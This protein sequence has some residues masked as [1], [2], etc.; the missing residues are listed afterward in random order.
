MD[1]HRDFTGLNKRQANTQ[2]PFGASRRWRSASD[3][4]IASGVAQADRRTFTEQGSRTRSHHE[5]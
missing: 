5:C 2:G 1:E 3:T 4:Q